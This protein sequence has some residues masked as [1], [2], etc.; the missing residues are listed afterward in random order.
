M[1]APAPAC[2]LFARPTRRRAIRF[3]VATV[4]GGLLVLFLLLLVPVSQAYSFTVPAVANC[5]GGAYSMGFPSG[6]PVRGVWGVGGGPRVHV[7]VTDSSGDQV[8]EG[9]GNSGA[10]SFTSTCSPY[11]FQV[12]SVAIVVGCNPVSPT[13]FSGSWS[14]PLL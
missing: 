9:T 8:Y 3:V 11:T 7:V 4:G 12:L 5:F 1:S 6:A 10:F 2:G 14:S 13:A